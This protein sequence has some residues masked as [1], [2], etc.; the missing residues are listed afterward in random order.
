M[1]IGVPT[2]YTTGVKIEGGNEHIPTTKSDADFCFIPA[3]SGHWRS[4]LVGLIQNG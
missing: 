2:Q 4:Y 3:S 1:Q